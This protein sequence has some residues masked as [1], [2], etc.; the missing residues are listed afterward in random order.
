[1]TSQENSL[2]LSKAQRLTFVLKPANF[3]Y[4]EDQIKFSSISIANTLDFPKISDTDSEII[5]TQQ[6]LKI[7]SIE[8]SFDL[9]DTPPNGDWKN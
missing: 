1:M 2:R 6:H 3:G 9:G 7:Y 8:F 5:I 4:V